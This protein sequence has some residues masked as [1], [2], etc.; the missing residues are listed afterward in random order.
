MSGDI[1]YW[2]F[3]MSI[4][5]TITGMVVY[6]LGKIKYI[7]RRVMFVL[8]AIPF[9]R[10]W[11]P[12]GLSSEYSLMTLMSELGT[13]TVVVWDKQITSM[14]TVRLAHNYFP[15]EYEISVFETLFDVASIIWMIVAVAIIV[16]VFTVY[17][18]SKDD[19]G[20]IERL[21]DNIYFSD[22]I[23][24]PYVYGI[25]RQKIILPCEYENKEVTYI[26][27]HEKVHISR[28]DNLWRTLVFVTV[29]I[30]WFNPFAWLFFKNF[31][32]D[33]ELSCDEKVLNKSGEKEKK[34]YAKELLNCVEKR[35]L[36]HS[37][38]GG[39]KIR[40]RIEN[41]MSYKKMSVFSVISFVIMMS[42][43]ASLLLTNATT[44]G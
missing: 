18:I 3:N 5:A 27:A 1:F 21:K 20:E 29:A 37:P 23:K 25:I 40:K 24:S 10:M 13:K 33:L 4:T 7:P 17:F 22:K 28:K 38:F 12:F 32:S 36:L 26:L 34:E 39:A 31:L 2:F 16:F 15:N 9:V 11:M 8:W 30:N 42:A 41:I 6:L 43:I 44:G 14:N 19:M 35:S